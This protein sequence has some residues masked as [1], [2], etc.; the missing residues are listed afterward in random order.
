MQEESPLR[1][2][3]ATGA[4]VDGPRR[5][6]GTCYS[7]AMT[8]TT[9]D[10]LPSGRV[11]FDLEGLYAT[12]GAGAHRF[13]LRC[14]SAASWLEPEPEPAGAAALLTGTVDV[15]T[16][17]QRWVGGL[18]PVLLTLRSYP[19]PTDL[20]LSVTDDQLVALD[21]ARADGGFE[22]VLTLQM[23][24]LEPPAGAPPVRDTQ[25]TLPVPRGRWLDLL[26]QLGRE[27]G[28]Q[29]RVPSPLGSSASPSLADEDDAASLSRTVARLR[30]ARSQIRENQW[31]GAVTSCRM[32]LDGVAALASPPLPTLASVKAIS[33]RERTSEQRWA[34]L[35]YDAHS[36]ASAAVHDDEVTAGFEWSRAD[37]E[38]L[39]A[40]T[41]ALL[42]H[43]LAT[44]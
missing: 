36:L 37:A 2:S 14:K 35:Y 12:A 4:M 13:A 23:A 1:L 34:S 29:I 25:V 24:L 6:S 39:L 44:R 26:D 5:S 30:Q 43:Y 38:G 31:A 18:Q 27:V 20:L 41:A 3:R 22:L 16:R 42:N 9:F 28:I 10:Y 32:A 21:L 15:A 7:W 19:V 11:R 40:M 33:P 8:T 17:G